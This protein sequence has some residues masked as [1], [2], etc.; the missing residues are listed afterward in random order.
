MN[1][2]IGKLCTFE[3]A[4]ILMN[5]QHICHRLTGMIHIAAPVDQGNGCG[6]L[7]LQQILMFLDTSHDDGCISGKVGG[8]IA[9]F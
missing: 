5:R 3:T 1:A 6:A 7:H 4:P 8:L 9:D 2:D